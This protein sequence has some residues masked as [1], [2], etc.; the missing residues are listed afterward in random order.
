MSHEIGV[1]WKI[2]VKRSGKTGYP[3]IEIEVVGITPRDTKA[4]FDELEKKYL[5]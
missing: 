1:A 5:K 4:W 2:K 3:D